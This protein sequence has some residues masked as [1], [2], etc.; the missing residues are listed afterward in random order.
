MAYMLTVSDHFRYH[1]GVE[2]D[3]LKMFFAFTKDRLFLCHKNVVLFS[4][5]IKTRSLL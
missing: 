3:A 5:H 2:T 4:S 1:Y